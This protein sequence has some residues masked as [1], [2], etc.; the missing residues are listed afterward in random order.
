M[1][2]SHLYSALW[3]LLV[4]AAAA[5][6]LAGCAHTDT[7]HSPAAQGYGS[8]KDEPSHAVVEKAAF[9]PQAPR[10]RKSQASASTRFFA[11]NVPPP[12]PATSEAPHPG[13]AGPAAVTADRP[14]APPAPAASTPSASEAMPLASARRTAEPA[15]NPPPDTA[16]IAARIEQAEMQLRIGNAKGARDIL[17]SAVEAGSIE[18]IVALARTYD[19]LELATLLVPPGTD[20]VQMAVRLYSDAAARGSKVAKVKLERLLAATAEEPSQ[21]RRR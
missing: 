1:L 17:A 8:L 16:S 19:P 12:Q 15:P 4:A 6:V 5:S 9:A 10:E 13:P 20:D 11:S 2:K 14:A 18:A 7:S 21:T 3:K